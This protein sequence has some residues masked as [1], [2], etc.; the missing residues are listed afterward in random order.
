MSGLQ[1]AAIQVA[2]TLQTAHIKKNPS[3]EHDRAP[4]TAADKKEPVQLDHDP[5]DDVISNVDE[6]EIPIS[7]LKPE[8]R[9]PQMPPLPDLRFEQSYL[10]SIKD[11]N[12]WHAVTYITIR[13]QVGISKSLRHSL[14]SSTN[15][16]PL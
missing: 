7:I 1:D 9:K 13:D 4:S 16:D 2:E 3:L 12:N 11:A 5:I 14:S 10:A 8:P 15:T 6:D